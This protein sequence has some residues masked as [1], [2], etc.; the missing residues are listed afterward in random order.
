MPPV[1]ATLLGPFCPHIPASRPLLLTRVPAGFPS[2]ADD[3]VEQELDLNQFVGFDA[4]TYCFRCEGDSMTDAGIFP[5]DVLIVKRGAEP[6]SGDIVI[7][8]INQE[9]TVKRFVRRGHQMWLVPESDRYE[10]ILICPGHELVVYGVV[11]HSVRT[12]GR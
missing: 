7:A 4:G 10:P 9:Y 6:R 1:P 12:H 5:G 11:S 8:E 2:P 3:Y